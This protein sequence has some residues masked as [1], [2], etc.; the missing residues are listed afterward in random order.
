MISASRAPYAV[1]VGEGKR[2]PPAESHELPEPIAA[3]IRT[4]NSGD[5][6]ER[7]P[8]MNHHFERSALAASRSAV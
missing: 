3:F 5:P 7:A 1:D 4:V 8:R 2:M 6:A